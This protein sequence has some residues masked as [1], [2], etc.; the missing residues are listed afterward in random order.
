MLLGQKQKLKLLKG[1]L[2]PLML[3]VQLLRLKF[4][5][6]DL[7]R[8]LKSKMEIWEVKLKKDAIC[9]RN[10]RQNLIPD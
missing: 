8:A 5:R 9:H 7:L 2:L 10:Q 1:D 3:L 6:P 4:Q